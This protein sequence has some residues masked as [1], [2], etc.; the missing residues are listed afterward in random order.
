MIKPVSE[1]DPSIC[2]LAKFVTDAFTS[3][4]S[5]MPQKVSDFWDYIN[6]LIVSDSVVPYSDRIIVP[7]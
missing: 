4:K 3:K 2:M 1:R 7:V 6:S 5:D